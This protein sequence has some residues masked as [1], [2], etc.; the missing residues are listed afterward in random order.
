MLA[1]LA[2]AAL[3]VVVPDLAAA[4]LAGVLRAA[5]TFVTV[6]PA[7]ERVLVPAGER[8][9]PGRPAAERSAGGSAGCSFSVR[10]MIR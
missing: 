1:L 5:G 6:V 3:R 9:R 7:V 10:S 4:F 8:V 2:A